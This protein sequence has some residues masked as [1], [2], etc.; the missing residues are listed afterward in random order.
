MKYEVFRGRVSQL[1]K[2][3]TTEVVG[4]IRGG[5]GSVET[6]VKTEQIFKMDDKVFRMF[7]SYLIEDGD[8]VVVAALRQ[9]DGY[10]R[11]SSCKN[12]TQRMGLV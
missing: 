9:K 5:R 6:K 7:C 10:F 12:F 3:T 11:I 8:E 2:D 4:K 1:Q